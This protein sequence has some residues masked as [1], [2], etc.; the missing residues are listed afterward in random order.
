MAIGGGILEI[1]IDIT[2]PENMF[3]VEN[4]WNAI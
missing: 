3:H 2:N 4:I 1:W